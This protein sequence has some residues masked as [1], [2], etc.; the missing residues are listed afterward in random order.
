MIVF[1]IMISGRDTQLLKACS[2]ISV[3]LSGME[4]S[5]NLTQPSNAYFS[6][7]AMV[8]GTVI[9]SRPVQPQNGPPYIQT[10]VPSKS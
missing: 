9:V 2:P 3:T 6:I 10:D 7:S 1:G 4:T 8:S 5:V